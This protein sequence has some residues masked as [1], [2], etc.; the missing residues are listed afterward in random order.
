MAAAG[1]NPMEHFLQFGVHE[2]RLTFADGV[3]G[4]RVSACGAMPPAET[5]RP[6][7]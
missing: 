1:I 6:Q 3:W 7:E 4:N 2:G 5:P